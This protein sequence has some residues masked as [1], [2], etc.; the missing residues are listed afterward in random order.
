MYIS[1]LCFINP[2]KFIDK[3]KTYLNFVAKTEKDDELKALL[4]N[5]HPS[6]DSIN[7]KLRTSLK[8]ISHSTLDNT[9]L[10][11]T[12]KKRFNNAVSYSIAQ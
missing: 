2:I 10:K 5:N 6:S 9:T 11:Y 12:P 4:L 1:F 8:S 3:E 7:I